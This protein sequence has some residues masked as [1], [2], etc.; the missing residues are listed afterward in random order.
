MMSQ[1]AKVSGS[2]WQV[3][4]TVITH[5][6]NKIARII[7]NVLAVKEPYESSNLG[8]YAGKMRR[9]KDVL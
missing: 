5:V 6:A 8:K 7:W 4:C 1:V 3:L 9:M 2:Y